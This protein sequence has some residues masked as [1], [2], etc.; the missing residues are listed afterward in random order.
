MGGTTVIDNLTSTSSSAALSANQGRVLNEKITALDTKVQ[1]L[2]EN[3][4]GGSQC[5]CA[6][7][8]WTTAIA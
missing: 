5:N 3:S 4:S 6:T 7:K 2:E 8:I 1:T